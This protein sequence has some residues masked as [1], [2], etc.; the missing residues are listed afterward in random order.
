VEGPSLQG[1][2]RQ[3]QGTTQWPG[4]RP[5]IEIGELAATH[6]ILSWLP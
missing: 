1:R 5:C 3:R 4:I 2:A 6:Q